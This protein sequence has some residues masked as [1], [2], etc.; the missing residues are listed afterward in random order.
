M[1]NVGP[2][3][4]FLD[5][6]DSDKMLGNS[7]G[8][9]GSRGSRKF[10]VTPLDDFDEEDATSKGRGSGYATLGQL[11]EQVQA[12]ARADMKAKGLNEFDDQNDEEEEYYEGVCMTGEEHTGRWTKEEHNLFLEGLKKFGKVCIVYST[13]TITK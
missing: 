6:K 5:S 11:A 1:T 7:F 12:K 9:Q 8:S 13:L 2:G 10:H 4:S 3:Y